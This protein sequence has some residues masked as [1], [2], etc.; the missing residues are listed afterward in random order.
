MIKTKKVQLTLS[1]P[2]KD[3]RY[4]KELM[5]MKKEESV[6]VSNFILSCV[7]KEIGYICDRKNIEKSKEVKGSKLHRK[8]K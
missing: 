6:N 5:R 7:K 1:F 4:K 8:F 2:E 3:I